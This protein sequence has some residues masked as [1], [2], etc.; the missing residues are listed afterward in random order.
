M[1]NVEG[2]PSRRFVYKGDLIKQGESI[3]IRELDA[4]VLIALPHELH[5][6]R[7]FDRSDHVKIDGLEYKKGDEI[8][9]EEDEIS[10]PL[11]ACICEVL[12]CD[13]GKF[14]VLNMMVTEQFSDK[15]NAY[16]VYF[17]EGIILVKKV[18]RME[19][20]WPLPIYTVNNG[21]LIVT[22]RA[23]SHVMHY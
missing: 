17:D 5:L 1:T 15:F 14:L 19:N 20:K 13:A 6:E 8:L 9:I 18:K 11:F 2:H 3:G 16:F 21:Q 22:N 23:F 7:L 12:C 4:D 10:G